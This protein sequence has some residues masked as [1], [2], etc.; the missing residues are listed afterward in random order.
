MTK[1]AL[2]GWTGSSCLEESVLPGTFLEG[3]HAVR[4]VSWQSVVLPCQ[5]SRSPTLHAFGRKK[6]QGRG[7]KPER[8]S[9]P[10]I[11]SRERS[12]YAPRLCDS[13][14][15]DS[16]LSGS[17]VGGNSTEANSSHARIDTEVKE[18]CAREKVTLEWLS[19][20]PATAPDLEHRAAPY[21]ILH[22]DVLNSLLGISR[23]QVC[24]RP[25][26]IIKG[27]HDNG[28]AVK[29]SV[30]CETCGEIANYWTSPRVDSKKT[31]NPLEV[32]FLAARAMVATGNG[33]TK[34][35]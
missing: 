14:A 35:N 12:N 24:C 28:L 33:Q 30:K 23:C 2:P 32:N 11:D 6:W 13:F 8:L 27:D 7:S 22:L 17:D 9:Q 29:L 25:A 26:S 21:I 31:C 4:T 18:K 20:T 16:A 15:T 10:L 3:L 5:E 34:M 1:I 19:S